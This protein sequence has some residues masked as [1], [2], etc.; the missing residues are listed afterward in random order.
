M[1]SAS[2]HN[3]LLTNLQAYYLIEHSLSKTF[4]ISGGPMD[5]W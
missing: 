4:D 5:K 3:V 2:R 1:A